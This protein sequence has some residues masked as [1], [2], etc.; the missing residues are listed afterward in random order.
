[1]RRR[2]SRHSKLDLCQYI[3]W[4]KGDTFASMLKDLGFEYDSHKY[5]AYK[6]SKDRMPV[7]FES[8]HGFND[9][10]RQGAAE[11][12]TAQIAYLASELSGAGT[13]IALMSRS[14][15]DLNRGERARK[16]LSFNL[17][18]NLQ[19]EG[20]HQYFNTVT[21]LIRVSREIHGNGNLKH[22][23]LIISVH[24][25]KNRK[26]RDIDVGSGGGRLCKKSVAEWV[27]VQLRS[28]L[29]VR[30]LDYKVNLDMGFSGGSHPKLLRTNEYLGE[31]LQYVQIELSRTIRKWNAVDMALILAEIAKDYSKN[32]WT[33]D[34][35]YNGNVVSRHRLLDGSAKGIDLPDIDPYD[36]VYLD[37]S[38]RLYL[39]IQKGQ[40]VDL[41]VGEKK[42]KLEVHQARYFQIG[43]GKIVLDRRLM[44]KI[45]VH[46]GQK[47]KIVKHLIN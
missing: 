26:R 17:D 5:L 13:I 29:S 19:K 1:M 30:G 47:V 18:R 45:G 3:I 24:G 43:D 2:I 6:K 10:E 28:R 20:T 27:A 23:L 36:R 9:V 16:T 31:K 39:N 42:I 7:F 11:P 22:D 14:V 21:D 38:Q 33:R 37:R 4:K 32:K 8:L 15:C 44:H 40:S 25:M 41:I 12:K 35:I 46:D 34:S